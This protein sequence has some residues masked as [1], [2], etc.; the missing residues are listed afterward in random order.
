MKRAF[1]FLSQFVLCALL[2][3]SLIA[4]FEENSVRIA[5]GSCLHQE[6]PQPIWKAI[7]K[8]KPDYF[9]FMGDNIYHDTLNAAE[10]EASY[11]KLK[12]S[13][14]FEGIRKKS[15]VLATWDDHDYGDN[16]SGGDYPTKKISEKLFEEIFKFTLAD[17][18]LYRDGIYQARIFGPKGKK[19]LFILPDTRYFRSPLAPGSKED[20]RQWRYLPNRD[21]KATVL[22]EVQW[23]WLEETLRQPADLRILVSSIELHGEEHGFENW[24]KFPNERKRLFDLIKKTAASKLIVLSGDR[25]RASISVN[26]DETAYPLYEIT[27]ST[28]NT[29]L[30]STARVFEPNRYRFEKEQYYEENFGLMTI[31]WKKESVHLELKDIDG[32]TVSSVLID[33]NELNPETP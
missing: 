15:T 12:E 7:L 20:P 23:N 14:E 5:F 29:P 22:G 21:P 25:H 32:K 9:I 24:A 11:L 33:L 8:T 16:D 17:E 10:K 2:F 26:R 1:K 19:I 18:V 3:S 27:S 30:P 4:C 31:D 6:K 13:P 28:F